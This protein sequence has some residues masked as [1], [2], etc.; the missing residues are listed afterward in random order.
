MSFKSFKSF[1]SDLND[2]NDFNDLNGFIYLQNM[3]IA[4]A[5]GAPAQGAGQLSLFPRSLLI[6]PVV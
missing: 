2:L 3:G 6:N 5:Q 4:P 1:A